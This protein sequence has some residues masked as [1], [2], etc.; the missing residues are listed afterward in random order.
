MKATTIAEILKGRWLDY[1]DPQSWCEIDEAHV[2]CCIRP[3][4]ILRTPVKGMLFR[5]NDR[6][7]EICGYD[8]VNC[9]EHEDWE[10]I[11]AHP[12][13]DDVND[14]TEEEWHEL[15]G[16]GLDP[17][18]DRGTGHDLRIPSQVATRER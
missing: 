3:E 1:S 2:Y 10:L 12:L 5:L 17:G 15:Y 9:I 13:K 11:Y 14:V 7:Y 16:D 4:A 6:T 18:V 8:Y